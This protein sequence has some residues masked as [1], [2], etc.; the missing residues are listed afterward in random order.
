MTYFLEFPTV[1]YDVSGNGVDKRVTDIMRRVKIRDEIKNN[2]TFWD[3]YSLRN[4]E[5]PSI[6]ANKFYGNPE[7]HWIILL[8]NNVINPY[9]DWILSY[10]E[11]ENFLTKKYGTVER[12]NAAHHYVTLNS[13]NLPNGLIVNSTY[14]GATAVTNRE[15]EDDENEKKRDIKIVKSSYV[16]QIEEE[17][18]SILE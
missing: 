18:K 1:D 9:H 16:S 8:T 2:L 17:L 13:F 10:H 11:L 12:I 14:S 7:L 5:S 4:G 6:L 15:F 3:K